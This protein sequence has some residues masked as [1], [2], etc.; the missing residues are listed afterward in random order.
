MHLFYIDG[1][2]DHHYFTFSA[3][4]VP[5][6][7]W[8]DVY[9]RTKAFRHKLRSRRG[10]ALSKELHATKFLSG[11]GRPADNRHVS[12]QSRVAIFNA[13]LRLV[14]SC[15]PLGVKL[16]NAAMD[17]EFRAFDR[18]LNRINVCMRKEGSMALLICDEGKEAQFA[19]LYRKMAVFNAIPSKFGA[20]ANGKKWANIP[21]DRILTD[22]YFARSHHSNF[23][24][25]A[26]FCAFALLR[27]DKPTAPLGQWGVETSFRWLEPVCVKAANPKDP[28]GVVRN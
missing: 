22:P 23:I 28:F 11:R 27:M 9:E 25:L 21:L 14:A 17:D 13:A 26:D 15:S 24:Q 19:Q 1:S 8:R 7:T 3:I 4:G 6:Q 16:I 10:I 20:W 5:E 18:L 12:R 2:A